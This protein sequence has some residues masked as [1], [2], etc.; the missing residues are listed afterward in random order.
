MSASFGEIIK[1]SS[2]IEGPVHVFLRLLFIALSCVFFPYSFLLALSPPRKHLP[3]GDFTWSPDG[4]N[5][6]SV[7]VR[8]SQQSAVLIAAVL[9]NTAYFV[10]NTSSTAASSTRSHHM[11]IYTPLLR[12]LSPLTRTRTYSSPTAHVANPMHPACCI[13]RSRTCMY[14]TGTSCM[15]F[16]SRV[17]TSLT[18]THDSSAANSR[19]R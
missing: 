9:S 1:L 17:W 18:G 4:R 14:N 5:L 12:S 15:Y 19:Y 8:Y 10:Y 13:I 16:T 3:T 2:I 6:E 7:S 11:L